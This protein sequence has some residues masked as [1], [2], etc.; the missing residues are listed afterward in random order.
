[1]AKEKTNDIEK[2]YNDIMNTI[3]SAKASYIDVLGVLGMIKHDFLKNYD[4][5]IK[6]VQNKDNER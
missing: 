1:M 6:N 5:A 3:Y 4:E 2:L